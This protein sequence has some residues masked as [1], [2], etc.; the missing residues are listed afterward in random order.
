MPDE[1]LKRVKEIDVLWIKN[2]KVEYSF[3]VENSTNITEA[4][5]RGSNIEYETN[6]FIVIPKRR[7]KLLHKKFE[8]PMIKDRIQKEKWDVITYEQ[9][10]EL[11]DRKVVKVEDLVD[12][13]KA[14][15]KQIE[16]KKL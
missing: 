9:V 12:M 15:D 5:I 7:F 10:D 4:I 11:L 6:R 16:Q 3:E 14:I 8:E 2:G 1:R 13:A